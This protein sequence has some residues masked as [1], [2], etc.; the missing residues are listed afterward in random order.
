MVTYLQSAEMQ[1]Q[2]THTEF[3]ILKAAS[4]AHIWRGWYDHISFS[5]WLNEQRNFVFFE[6]WY[7]LQKVK[8][9]LVME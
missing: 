3:E 1:E 8:H 6:V 4:E 5:S 9:T 2:L 7:K